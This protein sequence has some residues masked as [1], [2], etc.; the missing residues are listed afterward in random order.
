MDVHPEKI[1]EILCAEAYPVPRYCRGFPVRSLSNSQ[2]ATICPSVT[3][4]GIAALIRIP[5]G[6]CSS[7][8]PGNPGRRIVLLESVQD[9]GNVGTIIRTA[10]AF[11]FSGMFLSG[12]SA[13]PF[14]PKAVQASAGAV[15][16]LWI[17]RHQQVL[18]SIDGLK[19][20]GYRLYG[21]ALGGNGSVHFSDGIPLVIALG[22][23]GAG[24]SP[25]L[26]SMTDER[27]SIPMVD[28]AI[29]S[30]NVAVAGAIALFAVFRGEGW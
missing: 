22:N 23:E 2:F 30:L 12:D 11:G 15:L 7:N 20:S 21:T 19:K 27:F 5:E 28:G 25:E 17:R 3:P 24:L 18:A 4:Q 14:S 26:L 13:D 1:E 10:V 29:E 16:N 8:P 9:P 6:V